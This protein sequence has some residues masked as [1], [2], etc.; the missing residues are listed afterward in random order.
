MLGA[1][2][3]NLTVSHRAAHKFSGSRGQLTRIEEIHFWAADKLRDK[4]VLRP[5]IEVN[6]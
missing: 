5:F 3:H 2:T 6:R 4:G 1:D